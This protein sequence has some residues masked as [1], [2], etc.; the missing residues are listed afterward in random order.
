M[1]KELPVGRRLIDYLPPVLQKVREFRAINEANE[2]EFILAWAAVQLL[3]DNQFLEDATEIGV[4]VWEGEL[5]L[6]PKDG[7]TLDTRKARI[8]AMWNLRRPYTVPWLR[9]WLTAQCGQNG[10]T[11]DIE[12][13]TILLEL[14]DRDGDPDELFK[15]VEQIRPENMILRPILT[16]NISA[17]LYTAGYFATWTVTR[18]PVLPQEYVILT[19]ENG[20]ILTDENGAV[21][22]DAEEI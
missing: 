1:D 5:N 4:S 12:D 15:T 10:Y 20:V 9:Q 13:Y 2:P 17:T 3:L 18:L 11:L 7:D 16:Q 19:D 21:L 22:L 8:K 6:L 14:I